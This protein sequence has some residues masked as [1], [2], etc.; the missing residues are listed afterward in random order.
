MDVRTINSA[1]VSSLSGSLEIDS[2]GNLERVI[3]V[4]TDL[5]LDVRHPEHDKDEVDNLLA[6]AR[7]GLKGLFDRVVV[8]E[9]AR[10]A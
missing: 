1:H 5:H 7:A 9:A 3:T 10:D 4:E 8:K 2:D 6:A